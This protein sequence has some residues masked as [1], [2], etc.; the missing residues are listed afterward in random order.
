MKEL[1]D[2]VTTWKQ[3]QQKKQTAVLAT[4]IKVEGST[5]RRPGARML[6][7]KDGR[8]IGSISG[9]CL[10]SDVIERSRE[11][12][13]TGIPTLV[14][15]DTTDED[16]LIWGLGLGCQGVAYILIERLNTEE[17]NAL[18]AISC[19]LSQRQIS[20][21][22][23]VFRVESVAKVRTGDRLM[24]FP[25]GKIN[26]QIYD[27]KLNSDIQ[28]DLKTAIAQRKSINKAYISPEGMVEVFL[29]VIPPP[30]S[31]IIFG[32]GFDVLPLVHFAKQLGWY[33]SVVD[34]KARL[35]TKERF[36]E[37]DRIIFGISDEI[38]TQIE[39]DEQTV[40]VIMSHN[41]LYDLEFLQISI[42]ISLRYLGILGPRKR[43]D[44]LLQDLQT[45]GYIFQSEQELYSPVGLDIGADNPEE[46]ALAI[47]AEICSA[48]NHRQGGFLKNRPTPIH[49]DSN[50]ERTQMI[51]V[52]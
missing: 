35:Q 12:F 9:G 34:P 39:F 26:S 7:T 44:R 50:I 30:L 16:D 46:I 23:T 5:Y 11:V 18:D 52:Q 51:N 17:L 8:H 40:A 42:P 47:I 32:A 28:Q 10:E 25:D 3:L 21:V 2:I 36:R 37:C 38:K 43:T 13:E 49:S 14:K 24:L 31:L 20:A 19:C 41:Y 6:I 15:Y 45:E 27:R 29:E 1:Q 48:T 33:V 22:A 4:L